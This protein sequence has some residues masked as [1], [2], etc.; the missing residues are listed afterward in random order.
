M[1]NTTIK[2]NMIKFQI[3][4]AD[5]LG[6][7]KNTLSLLQGNQSTPFQAKHWQEVYGFTT[8]YPLKTNP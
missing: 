5:H 2:T 4:H 6:L 1:A 8:N 7:Q 3:W